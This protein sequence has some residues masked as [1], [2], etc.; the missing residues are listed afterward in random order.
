MRTTITR[1]AVMQ[2]VMLFPATLF[3]SSVL[4]AKGDP[5][6]YDLALFAQHI[7]TWYSTRG[8]TLFV[9][10][11]G[12]PF[13]VLVTGCITLFAAPDHNVPAMRPSLA[14]ILVSWA[15]LTSAAVMGIVVLHMLAN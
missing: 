3:L 12:L 15:T 11:L 7:V 8:W 14:T 4:V 6:Q 9:L 5:P 1:A 10:L 13:A 2:L